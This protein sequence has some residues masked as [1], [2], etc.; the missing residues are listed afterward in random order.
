MFVAAGLLGATLIMHLA[1]EKTLE[2]V[3]EATGETHTMQVRQEIWTAA[4]E[5]W[6]DSPIIGWGTGTFRLA[7]WG[8]TSGFIAHNAFITIL[9]ETG[10]IGLGFFVAA[11][12]MTFYCVCRAP[13][14]DR[15]F[16]WAVFV[17]WFLASMVS[18]WEYSKSGWLMFS[19]VTNI[20]MT[21]R[22]AEGARQAPRSPPMVVPVAPYADSRLRHA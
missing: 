12:L 18:P 21:L 19:L 17:V 22:A 11:A 5:R 20:C 7:V 14:E 10:L 8:P 13:P 1:P 6:G 9:V 4:L 3:S 15:P 16:F 2:R